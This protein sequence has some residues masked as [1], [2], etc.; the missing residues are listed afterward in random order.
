MVGLQWGDI[1]VFFFFN[2]LF[3]EHNLFGFFFF[4]ISLLLVYLFGCTGSSSWHL[5]S[6][7]VACKILV[8]T[9]GI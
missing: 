7:V 2:S 6:L 5:R 1:T 9:C 3:K 8:A 4:N